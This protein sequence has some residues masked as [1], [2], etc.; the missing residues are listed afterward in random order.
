MLMAKTVALSDP[1][2]GNQLGATLIGVTD[3]LG[4]GAELRSG[5]KLILAQDRMCSAL[6]RPAE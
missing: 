6:P 4:F 1:K 5:T 3:R 2:A